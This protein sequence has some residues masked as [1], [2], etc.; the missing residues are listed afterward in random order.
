MQTIHNKS[1]R[2]MNQ[3]VRDKA[4]ALNVHKLE[5]IE[6]L[7][8]NGNELNRKLKYNKNINKNRSYN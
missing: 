6:K 7:Q 2:Q 3:I 8:K 4:V 1:Q 5:K